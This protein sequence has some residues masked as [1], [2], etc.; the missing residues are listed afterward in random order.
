MNLD[1]EES[2]FEFGSKDAKLSSIS[3]N[4]PINRN[5][6]FDNKRV[7]RRRLEP[8]DE[9]DEPKQENNDD[10][11]PAPRERPA[12]DEGDDE[13]SDAEKEEGNDDDLDENASRDNVGE[14]SSRPRQRSSAKALEKRKRA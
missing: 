7:K 1:Q 2:D 5:R 6:T 8:V 10:E 11:G 9:K 4:T 13:T 14:G 12:E 3:L